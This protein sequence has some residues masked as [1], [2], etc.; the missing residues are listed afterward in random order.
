MRRSILAVIVGCTLFGTSLGVSCGDSGGAGGAGGDEG[1][2]AYADVVFEGGAT[3]E[4]LDA[5][6]AATVVSDPASAANFTAPAN[7]AVLPAATVPTFSWKI[8][9]V[10]MST[11]PADGPRFA[12][13]GAAMS[14]ATGWLT[15][16]PSAIDAL[17]SRGLAKLLDGVPAAYAH[18]TPTSGPAF[19]VLFTTAS[20]D[21]LLRVFTSSTTYTPSA[22]AFAKLTGAGTTIHAVITNAEFDQNR[23]AQDGGP[24]KGSEITFTVM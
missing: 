4:A 3:D 19:F 17:A 18:G 12:K 20:N 22:D 6:V 24:W 13:S 15:M 14:P 11:P 21:K 16:P 5:L 7:M 2:P 1:N 23:I 8:G 9:A 10:A